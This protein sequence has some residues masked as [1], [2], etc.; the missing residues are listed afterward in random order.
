MGL[1]NDDRIPCNIS[2]NDAYTRIKEW[3]QNNIDIANYTKLDSEYRNS[4]I[5]LIKNLPELNIISEL[6]MRAILSEII[7]G[8]LERGYHKDDGTYKMGAYAHG[9]LESN[10]LSWQLT[11]I[12]KKE[13]SK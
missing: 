8:K 2:L 1:S 4:S 3:Y 5:K 10:N 11:E 9:A 6:E 7:C 12:E 13:L